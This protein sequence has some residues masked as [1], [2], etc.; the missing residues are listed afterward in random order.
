MEHASRPTV[1]VGN[2]KMYKTEDE[3]LSFL[4]ALKQTLTTTI[5]AQVYLAVP[6]TAIK[7]MASEEHKSNFPIKIGAQNMH[8]ASEGAFT[9][10]ISGKML[11]SVGADFVIL[12]HSER[13]KL[14]NENNAFINRKVKR[15]LYDDIQPILC[16][17]E[18]LQEHNDGIKEDVLKTQ[19]YDCL[20]DITATELEKIILAYEPV[21]A[22]GTD[23]AATPEIAEEVHLYLR[24][25]VTEKWGP[26]SSEKLVIL[27]GGSVKTDNAAALLNKID[28]DGLLIGGAS[29]SVD[30][31]NQIINAKTFKECL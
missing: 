26:Q 4:H 27:Y 10:E 2:W 21:W 17:G 24:H 15:A 16:I 5:T 19:L 30:S 1:I 31:F 9:G 13:R 29:L 20:K 12:G 8:D 11:K 14:F 22:I 7:S 25:L 18:T 23:L 28:I 3:C 6:F